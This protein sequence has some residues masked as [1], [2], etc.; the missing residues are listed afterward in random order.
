MA[1]EPHL[2]YCTNVHPGETWPEVRENLASHVAAVKRIL[3]PDGPFGV[4]L[5]LSAA[6]AEALA[7]PAAR[8]ELG[9]WLAAEGMY[10]FTI[11]GFP[12]GAFHG[13]RVKERVYE[14]DWRDARRVAYSGRLATLLAA[15]LPEDHGGYGSVSSVPGAFRPNAAG[16]AA[17]AAVAEGLL[18]HAAH[19]AALE[20]E[21]GRCVRLALEP[22]P[23]CLL[24]TVED[25]VEFFHAHLW[26]A[27][28]AIR[29]AAHTGRTPA[30]CAGLLRR[31]LGLCFDACHMAVGFAEPEA[32]L[33][34]LR[35]A[36]IDLVKVQVSAGMAATLGGDGDA[37]TRA[38]LAAFADDVYLHQVVERRG[39]ALRRFVDLPDALAAALG[40]RSLREWRVHFHV[41]L[42]REDLGA[43][44]STQP[45]TAALLRRLA[46]DGYA[47]HLEV[48]TYTWDVLP[49][50]FRDEPVA[51][52]VA[53]E[54]RWTMDRLGA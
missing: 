29:L 25:A 27:A 22:E 10:V 11:N 42:F 49:A 34:R 8:A 26:T 37:T 16:A 38:A 3:A 19:L 35:A 17:R 43:L 47:G 6:A 2:T 54:L 45:W 18:R 40:D 39:G 51:A 50:R 31:H 44:R 12:Y 33:A 30:A 1:G 48:E 15:L 4:G 14:P 9:A 41:P 20:S 7:A 53:R 46:A 24:E 13:A 36:E 21:T 5:R 32:A 52:A 28:A 23:W